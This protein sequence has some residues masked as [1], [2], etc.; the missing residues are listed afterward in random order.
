[1]EKTT[2][3]PLLNTQFQVHTESSTP[4]ALTLVEV[5]DLNRF[6][7]REVR[8]GKR[9]FSLLFK[10]SRE[11]FLPQRLYPFEHEAL[12]TFELFIVPVH[13]DDDQTFSYEAIFN[14]L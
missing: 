14:H 7:E 12:G 1:M 9:G 4:V 5:S 11:H 6:P 8:R 3:L 10:G 13:P 2:F